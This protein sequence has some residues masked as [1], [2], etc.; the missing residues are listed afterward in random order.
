MTS[1]SELTSSK[2]PE[3]GK[4]GTR[5]QLR[6]S[7]VRTTALEKLPGKEPEPRDAKPPGI[8]NVR[9]GTCQPCKPIEDFVEDT[10]AGC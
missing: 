2:L 10:I 6:Q 7:V 5:V 9:L 1:Q 3:L 8:S 4:T